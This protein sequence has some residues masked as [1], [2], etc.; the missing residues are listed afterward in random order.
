MRVAICSSKA[1]SDAGTASP[2]SVQ[3][4]PPPGPAQQTT[5]TLAGSSPLAIFSRARSLRPLSI[6][7]IAKP[8]RDVTE[9]AMMTVTSRVSYGS[10]TALI[11]LD[12]T[13]DRRYG[14]LRM[15]KSFANEFT[16][17]LFDGHGTDGLP[18]ALHEPALLKLQLLNAATQL[19]DLEL[20]LGSKL[21]ILEGDRRGKHCLRVLNQG[22][23]CFRWKDGHA[24][25]VEVFLDH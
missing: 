20:A 5:V 3:A 9:A 10:T 2:H 18:A 12:V 16:R 15:I 6:V 17:E 23:L 7:V 24:Y 13:N 22:R 11:T 8:V 21:E 25:D 14:P 4:S 1:I 19:S